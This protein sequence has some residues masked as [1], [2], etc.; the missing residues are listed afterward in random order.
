MNLSLYIICYSSARGVE[1]ESV[2][3][4]MMQ[5]VFQDPFSIVLSLSLHVI[6]L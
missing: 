5:V 6:Q 2:L 1:L 3:L 4:E